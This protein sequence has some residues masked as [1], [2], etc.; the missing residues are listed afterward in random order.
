MNLPILRRIACAILFSI[1]F[2]SPTFGQTVTAEAQDSILSKKKD[3]ID[4]LQK[5]FHTHLRKDSISMKGNGPF[6]S[7]MPVVGY[8]LQSGLTGA[9]VSNTSFYTDSTHNKFSNLL[10]N[11]YYSEYHQY[12]FTANTNIFYEKY[13]LH[14]FGDTRYYNFPTQTFGYGTNSELSDDLDIKYSYLRICQI[15]Y[16]EIVPNTFVGVGYNL[17]F[18]W[19]L[20]IDSVPGKALKDLEKYQKGTRSVSSGIS[21]NFLFDNRTNSVNP[22]GGYYASV[23]YRPNLTLLGSTSNWQSLLVDLRTYVKFPA[24]SHNILAFWSYNNMTL[25]GTPPYLDMPSVGWDAYSNTGRGYVPGR[26]VG[27][28]FNYLESEYRFAITQNGI[29]GGVVFGNVEKVYK[30]WTDL[31][32]VIPGEGVGIRIKLNKYSSTNLAIDY[33]F[34][35]GGSH[36]LFFNLGEVF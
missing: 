24:S 4:I 21:L 2:Y 23:Q 28:K 14:L 36:G 26:Y 34:G 5:S 33:G 35:V 19:N 13:K 15:I 29:L 3:V 27:L 25:N 8:S 31:H 11:A 17:D 12:W 6:I 9:I 7:V 18:H 1:L 32:T 20:K 22:N 10:L 30:K 16:R